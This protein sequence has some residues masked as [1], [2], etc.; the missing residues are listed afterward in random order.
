LTLN[1]ADVLV[2]TGKD[3]RQIWESIQGAAEVCGTTGEEVMK[4][5]EGGE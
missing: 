4:L 5:A 1:R 2:L 3:K